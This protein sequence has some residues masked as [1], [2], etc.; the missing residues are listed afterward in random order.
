LHELHAI[1]T[2]VTKDGAGLLQ[3]RGVHVQTD[4]GSGGSDDLCEHEQGAQWPATNVDRF[5]PGS[6]ADATQ[7]I[8][9]MRVAKSGG[10]DQSLDFDA[11]HTTGEIRLVPLNVSHS[12][13][14]G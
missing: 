3:A 4:D 13:L 2:L 10:D 1:V 6:D 5:L 11:I 9:Y 8:P 7:P 14:P 12:F